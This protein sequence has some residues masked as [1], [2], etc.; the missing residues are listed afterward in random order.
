MKGDSVYGCMVVRV[1]VVLYR[2]EVLP[3][4][5]CAVHLSVELVGH[6][7]LS[8]GVVKVSQVHCQRKNKTL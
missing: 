8:I 3:G 4:P 5:L 6:D 7:A 2:I 1:Y